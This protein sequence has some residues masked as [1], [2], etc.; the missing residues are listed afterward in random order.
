[1]S[2]SSLYSRVIDWSNLLP[3][4]RTA[5]KGK[6]GKQ[7]AAGF[8]H[9]VADRLLQLQQELTEFSYQPG[10]YVNFMIHDPKQRRVSA[11]PFRDRVVH[12]ALCNVIEPLFERQFIPDS[13]ANRIG[14]GSHLAVDRLQVFARRY[15]YVLRMDIVKHFPAIDHAVMLENLRATIKEDET[16][17]LVERIIRSG[18]GVLAD[19]YEMIYFPGDDLFAVNRPRGLPI[20][21]LTSQFWSNVYLTPLDLFV[22]RD[23]RCPAYLRYVD[24]F[25]CFSDSKQQLYEW[26]RAIV[27]FLCGLRLTIHEPQ[28]QVIPCEHGIPWLGF[29]VYPTHRR[30]KARNVVKFSRRLRERWGEYCGGKITFAEFDASV[31]GWINHVRYADSWGLRTHA[32]GQGL[33]Y[34]KPNS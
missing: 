3:A 22:L 23:L 2:D 15:R 7:S 33:V 29:V 17:W 1:M 6:R 21:N 10:G 27:D 13:Y 32:L 8:E 30:V 14:K 28:A 5:A 16:M 12:H 31:Q 26:K 18:E 4:F 20:G 19:E 11:A 9:Q 25:A 34:H 24:D